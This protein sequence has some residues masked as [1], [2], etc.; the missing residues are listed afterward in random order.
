[1]DIY[2]NPPINTYVTGI[3][4]SFMMPTDSGGIPAVAVT[5]RNASLIVSAYTILVLLVFTLGWHLILSIIMGFWP[6][7]RDPNRYI[8]LVALWNSSE[9]MNATSV[10]LRYCVRMF[11]RPSDPPTLSKLGSTEKNQGT[12][13][14]SQPPGKLGSGNLGWGILFLLIA[15]TMSLGNNAAG[16][17]VGGGLLMGNVAPPAKDSIFFPDVTKYSRTDD[18]G[19]SIAK[20]DSLKAPSALRALGS[21][22][23]SD[24]TVRNLV[25]LEKVDPPVGYKGDDGPWAGLKYDYNVTGVDMGLQSD[26]KLRLHVEGSCNTNYTW[27]VNST[28]KGDTYRLFDQDKF[29]TTNFQPEVNFPPMVETKVDDSISETDRTS[30]AMIINT[31]GSYSFTSSSDPWYSTEATKGGGLAYQVTRKRPVLICSERRR[32]HLNGKN[33]ETSKLETLP[34]LTLFKLWIDV[35]KMEFAYPRVV[36]LARAAGPAA[37]KS[38]TFSVA[39]SFV[40]DAEASNILD[41]LERLV[42]ASWVS[43]RS[44]LRDTTTYKGDK[45]VNFAKGG[46]GE[47]EDSATK[48]VLQSGDVGTLSVRILISIPA[49]LL[50]LVVVDIC[51][52]CVLRHGNFQDESALDKYVKRGNEL[53]ATQL[54]RRLDDELRLVDERTRRDRDEDDSQWVDLRGLI[55][56]MYKDYNAGNAGF[57]VSEGP[58]NRVQGQEEN[59]QSSADMRGGSSSGGASAGHGRAAGTN[60]QGATEEVTV[61]P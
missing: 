58:Y 4:K 12:E 25:I 21:I 50:F 22:E 35:F 14:I 49:V 3:T 37:L 11:M 5:R 48:F 34:G 44:V 24:V 18:N 19:A 53:Q 43:S 41:D 59:G 56:A 16:V 29:Y 13:Q 40:L 27:I 1:M 55:P 31:G 47:V 26:P 33:V 17:L 52:G 30:F 8:A 45:M 46:R 42:L 23:A 7:N 54:C 2:T 32:W 20:L 51:L 36:S 10:M 39:P 9:S 6:T 61:A 60:G 15:L 28:D 38:A 57:L